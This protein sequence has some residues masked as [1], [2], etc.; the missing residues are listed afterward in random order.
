M[1]GVDP[2]R[3]SPDAFGHIADHKITRIDE[4]LTWSYA[5]ALA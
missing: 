3:G 1:N 2:R 5:E 4:P